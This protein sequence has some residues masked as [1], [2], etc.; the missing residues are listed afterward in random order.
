[1]HRRLINAVDA[2]FSCLVKYLSTNEQSWYQGNG[3]EN[4]E[5]WLVN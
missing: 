3:L 1:M 4:F 5:R 2:V